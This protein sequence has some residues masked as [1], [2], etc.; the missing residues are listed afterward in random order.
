MNTAYIKRKVLGEGTY[1]LIFL[2]DEVSTVNTEKI[3]KSDKDTVFKRRVAIKRIKTT[4]I[5]F[6]IEISSIRE[7]KAL[8]KIK[9]PY[10]LNLFDVFIYQNS[11][12]IILEYIETNLEVIIKNKKI[13]LMPSDIKSWLLMILKGLYAMHKKFVIHRDIKPNNILINKLGIVKIADFGL[14]REIDG[15]M[16]PTVVTR[17]YRAPELLF[18]SKMYTFGVDMWAVGCVFAELFLRVP[19]FGGESD[20]HQLELIFQVLGNPEKSWKHCETLSGYVKYKK[21]VPI[22]FATIF[23]GCS[24]DALDLL[25]KMLTLDA[26]KRITCLN[27][28]K[29]DYFTN[30]PRPTVPEKLP[31]YE[32][33]E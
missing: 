22:D 18:N 2:A 8:K 19:F 33:E 17:W 30:L 4:D 24:E 1:A 16:T 27:A 6:G 10:V 20:F 31:Y 12:H 9:S 26:K 3:L 32:P 25:K 11:M 14:A 5:A 7:I 15:D 21:S 29:H 13:I 28:L 23:T